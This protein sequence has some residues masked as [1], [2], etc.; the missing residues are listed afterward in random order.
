[1][2]SLGGHWKRGLLVEKN[3]LHEEWQAA[4]VDIEDLVQELGD[5]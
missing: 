4:V 5:D 2:A 1:M 3:R